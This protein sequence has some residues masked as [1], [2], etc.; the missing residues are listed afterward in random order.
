MQKTVAIGFVGT[1]LDY[2]GKGT[3]RWERWRPSVGLCQ[4]EDLVIHRLELLH[5]ARSRGL[6][7]RLRDDIAPVSP[8]TE[9]RSVEIALR[10]PWDFEEVYGMLHDFARGYAF[11]TDAEDYLIHITTGT[12]V[13]Q[14]CWFLLA[15]ARYLPARLVQTSPPRKKAPGNI[16]GSYALIDLDLSRY[17]RIATRFA[18][19]REDTVSRLKSGIATRNPAFNRMIEQIERV[20]SRSRSPMLLFGPTGAG[21][22]F[23]A[24]RVYEMKKARHQ[25]S[26]RFVEVNCA[27]LR[28][29]SA[30]SALFG[31][32]KG[33]FTGAQTDRAGLLRSAD[34]G[35]LFLDEIGELG[36]DEQAMLLKAIEEKRFLPFGSDREAQSDF[37]LIAGTVR[38]LRQW[39]AEG[40]FRE[41]LF[42][43]INLWTFDL[44]G[45][46]QRPEDIE[47]NLDY[48]LVRFAREHG[49][50]VRFHTEARRAYLRFVASPQARWSGN[51]RELSASVTR[52]ATLAEGGRITEAGVEAEIG[53]LRHAWSGAEAPAGDGT[54]AGLLGDGA[55]ALDRF[56]R[57]QLESVVRICRESASL[58]DAGRRLFDV[59]R[60]E[61]AKVND[62]DR[63]RKYLAR[64]G[65][66]WQQVRGQA[67]N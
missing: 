9:V 18:R 48:E 33:A 43:R 36:L 60:L 12:H 61:K 30:M 15:E 20:A 44:P 50:Q 6:F 16:A 62:A 46:A 35:L 47:P 5:D 10:D 38:D 52:L 28:G 39:V 59:S 53:R 54:L 32:V 42:A 13:A 29:D 23:L 1:V 37:Q 27:T 56:D 11:D 41:D 2:A 66:D 3:Q 22:S 21:K 67:A 19:E 34:G 40:R 8:E 26:G 64:F 24:R 31:H 63:L 57:M 51:F 4:Q 65:L 45:L 14:I 58:S 55:A 7:E 25:L 49:E 17:D